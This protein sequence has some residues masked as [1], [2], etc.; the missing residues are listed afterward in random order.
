MPGILECPGSPEWTF[1]W[2]H[3][4]ILAY[5]YMYVN[6]YFI[7]RIAIYVLHIA[8][9]PLQSLYSGYCIYHRVPSAWIFT[10]ESQN[11][12]PCIRDLESYC[13]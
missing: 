5:V 11:P 2:V 12:S 7:L 13:S 10:W 8:I 1:A 3:G 6:K 4:I 9:F